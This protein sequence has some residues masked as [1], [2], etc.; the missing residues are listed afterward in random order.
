MP[1]RCLHALMREVIAGAIIL[2]LMDKLAEPVSTMHIPN[3]IIVD[4]YIYYCFIYYIP[5]R[6]LLDMERVF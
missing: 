5:K 3:Y 6:A 4:I 1:S 2:P